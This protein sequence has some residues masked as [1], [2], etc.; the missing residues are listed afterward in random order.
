MRNYRE[1]L[2]DEILSTG[3]FFWYMEEGGR[4]RL[5]STE[6][7]DWNR[8]PEI[9]SEGTKEAPVVMLSEK[10]GGWWE[11]LFGREPVS[12]RRSAG[13]WTENRPMKY[14]FL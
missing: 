3:E 13:H 6:R 4:L 14:C 9:F 7:I 11:I 10:K 5:E 8:E 1:K 12:Y 2:L